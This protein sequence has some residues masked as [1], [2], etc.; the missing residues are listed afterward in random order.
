M[1]VLLVVSSCYSTYNLPVDA[2]YKLNGYRADENRA[3]HDATGH[4]HEFNQRKALKLQLTDGSHID[5]KFTAIDVSDSMLTGRSQDG[6]ITID[7]SQVRTAKLRELSV[8]KSVGLSLGIGI[9]L[10]IISAGVGALGL[11]ALAL[12]QA[13]RH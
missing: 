3:V 5:Y 6:P 1:P 13:F 8:G 2:L 12:Q 9:P 4:I 7:L 11:G 10:L